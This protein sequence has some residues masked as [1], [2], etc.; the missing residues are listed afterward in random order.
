MNQGMP[1]TPAYFLSEQMLGQNAMPPQVDPVAERS[2]PMADSQMRQAMGAPGL[3][4][5]SGNRQVVPQMRGPRTPG[6][7]YQRVPNSTSELAPA[8]LPRRSTPLMQAAG[9]GY[10]PEGDLATAVSRMSMMPDQ[11][12]VDQ[13]RAGAQALGQQRYAA[14]SEGQAMIGRTQQ[15]QERYNPA[16]RPDYE[17][18][19]PV[20]AAMVSRNTYR[21]GGRAGA[22]GGMSTMDGSLRD[23]EDAIALAQQAAGPPRPSNGAQ[24]R[25]S[26]GMMQQAVSGELER[27]GGQYNPNIS[28]ENN[29]RGM[30]PGTTFT[31]TSSTGVPVI[32]SRGSAAPLTEKQQL[33][34]DNANRTAR[35]ARSGRMAELG[36]RRMAQL[37]Q[38]RDYAMDP[39]NRLAMAAMGDPRAASSLGSG[40]MNSRVGMGQNEV[41][42]QGLQRQ[43]GLDAAAEERAS[44]ELQA[45]LGLTQ[46][47]VETAKAEADLKRGQLD[48]IAGATN[49]DPAT[50]ARTLMSDPT[51][52]SLLPPSEQRR[53]RELSLGG[54]QGTVTGAVGG[55][56][57]SPDATSMPQTVT[58]AVGSPASIEMAAESLMENGPRVSSI[59][60]VDI[61]T[62]S[63]EEIYDSIDKRKGSGSQLSGQ[64]LQLVSQALAERS[65][66]DPEFAQDVQPNWL[67]GMG[68]IGVSEAAAKKR[69]EL[70]K[71]FPGILPAPLK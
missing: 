51:V 47:Q 11:G 1:K 10:T 50:Y 21:S 56:V 66:I 28:F 64:D 23:R 22:M 55:A 3:G 19:S 67:W 38:E 63:P 46:A 6:E 24:I 12:Y 43:I 34:R 5:Y 2:G 39:V 27:M 36:Q 68:A 41:A 70:R 33:D 69:A 25:E 42:N 20:Q 53:V 59:L 13:Q 29:A 16:G 4:D 40:I 71:Q 45:R 37:Q 31:G 17:S 30:S 14:S 7:T 52:F 44:Q 49:M 8:T 61:M 15:A 58:G 32:V 65:K 26:R 60:G 57:A 62:A 54:L 9:G 18:M 35:Q 48:A